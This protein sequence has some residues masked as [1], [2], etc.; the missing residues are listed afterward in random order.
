MLANQYPSIC[1]IG[2]GWH[3][4]WVGYVEMQYDLFLQ[5]MADIQDQQA[6]VLR[7]TLGLPADLLSADEIR[8]LAARRQDLRAKR[9]E[10]V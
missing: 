1:E 5:W 8:N 3:Q 2:Q 9:M 7:S 10:P 6:R 4:W